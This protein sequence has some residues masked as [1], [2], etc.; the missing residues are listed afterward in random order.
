[1]GLG[2]AEENLL[3]VNFFSLVVFLLNTKCWKETWKNSR[4]F[5]DFHHFLQLHVLRSCASITHQKQRKLCR[6][7]QA[8]TKPH[9]ENSSET[10]EGWQKTMRNHKEE[11]EF[12]AREARQT[13]H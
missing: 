9:T 5:P 12:H 7:F 4:S 3:I 6:D 8:G 10:Q 13:R 2:G 11:R 1:M